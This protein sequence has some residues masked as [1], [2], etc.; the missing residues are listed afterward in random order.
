MNKS[1]SKGLLS[2]FTCGM[3]IGN[4]LIDQDEATIQSNLRS[5]HHLDRPSNVFKGPRISM[6]TDLIWYA[7]YDEDMKKK[8][9]VD[10]MKL[11]LPE[12]KVTRM[13]AV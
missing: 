12:F 4:G 2:Q 8:N 9:F 7:A 6:P 10:R 13:M 11:I 1:K 3:G 5:I